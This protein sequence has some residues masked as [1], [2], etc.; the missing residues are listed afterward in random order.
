MTVEEKLTRLAKQVGLPLHAE[1]RPA[2]PG[3]R[4]H[5]MFCLEDGT[6]FASASSLKHGR[7]EV[8][9]LTKL[10]PELAGLDTREALTREALRTLL[11]ERGVPE[12]FLEY[13]SFYSNRGRA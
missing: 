9:R 7:Y 13:V 1:V 6:E 4:Q 8:A 11:T 3:H 10:Y 5:Y 2:R 12:L